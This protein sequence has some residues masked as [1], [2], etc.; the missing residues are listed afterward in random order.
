MTRAEA[1]T[2][3]RWNG[4]DLTAAP[5]SD[6]VAYGGC[7]DADNLLAA[8]RA[9]VFPMPA[10]DPATALINRTLH[11]P[12]VSAGRITVLPGRADPFTLAWH[13]PDPMPVLPVDGVHVSRSL[14]RALRRR[15]GGWH[16][17]ADQAFARVVS[18]CAEGR[19]TTWL[20]DEL[21]AAL[22]VLHGRGWAHSVEVWDGDRLVGGVFGVA[23]G[24]V[25][26]A[27]SMFHTTADASKVA[28]LD[29]AARL[30]AS[31]VRSIAVQ[32]LS[33]HVTAAGASAV[34]RAMFLAELARQDTP[35][36]LDPTPA[37]AARL[38]VPHTQES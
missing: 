4:I 19:T 31:T 34:P 2:G 16:T 21:V 11:E 5:T 25:F 20:N 38:A 12:D 37:A 14:R 9:G 26:S 8:Y 18:G 22:H 33:A 7:I 28:V 30:A 13:C 35:V 10:D 1:V 3:Y 27:D 29:L 17:T 6:P 23:I 36:I 24:T 15:Y 32:V